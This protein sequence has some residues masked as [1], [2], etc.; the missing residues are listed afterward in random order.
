MVERDISA[1]TFAKIN[2]TKVPSI[3]MNNYKDLFVRKDSAHFEKYIEKVAAGKAKISG[4]V[5][6][7]S[8]L[9]KQAMY[10]LHASL[11][12][13][14][15]AK[16]LQDFKVPCAMLAAQCTAPCSP[17]ILRHW[18]RPWAS[19]CSSLRSPRPPSAAISLPLVSIQNW[20][21]STSRRLSLR[22]SRGYSGANGA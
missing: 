6:L 13:N 22:K 3:A 21:P 2:Y 5:L 15:N 11:P 8:Q 14:P 7:P 4:A 19:P 12:K 9:V 18:T 20:S 1:E 17:T 10:A 16:R